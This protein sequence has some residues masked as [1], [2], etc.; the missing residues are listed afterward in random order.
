M[1]SNAID[2]GKAALYSRFFIGHPIV[3]QD[4]KKFP[5]CSN[6]KTDWLGTGGYNWTVSPVSA[7]SFSYRVAC[8]NVG[9]ETAGTHDSQACFWF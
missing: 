5:L 4:L 8:S 6:L 3:Y 9:K 7:R 1:D 2:C